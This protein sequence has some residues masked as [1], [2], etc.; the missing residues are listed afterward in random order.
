MPLPS[1]S[2]SD[3][4][5]ALFSLVPVPDPQAIWADFFLYL[6]CL[7]GARESTWY[8]KSL[9]SAVKNCLMYM[10]RQALSTVNQLLVYDSPEIPAL[11]RLTLRLLAAKANIEIRLIGD[12]RAQWTHIGVILGPHG[13]ELSAPFQPLIRSLQTY[14][15]SQ[16]MAA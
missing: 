11:E 8:N 4:S 5:F 16:L 13:A 10:W 15:N 6:R 3:V 7:I 12:A 2:E 9:N 14:F 1:Y